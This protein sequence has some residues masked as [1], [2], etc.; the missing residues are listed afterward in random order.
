MSAIT[1]HVLDTSAGKPAVGVP[2]TLEK[3][4]EEH[5]SHVLGSAVTDADGRA[6][7]L[8]TEDKPLKAGTYRLTFDTAAYFAAQHV[9]GFYPTVAI[10][11]EVRDASQH[12]HVPLLLTPH[13]YSTYRGS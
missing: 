12:Y 10:L 9:Q 3:M 7:S 6:R 8:L 1:T 13:G 4:C 2:V 11:F 5:G